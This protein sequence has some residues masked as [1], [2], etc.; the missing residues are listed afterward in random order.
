MVVD[1]NLLCV[2]YRTFERMKLLCELQARAMA[3]NH[4]NDA[5]QMASGTLEPRDDLRVRLVCLA[6]FHGRTLS[7]RRGYDKQQGR[8]PQHTT[9]DVSLPS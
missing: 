3:L 7:P 5:A 2:G 1:E 9:S 6:W 8:R 4:C